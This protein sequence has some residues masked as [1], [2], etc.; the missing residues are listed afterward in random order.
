MVIAAVSSFITGRRKLL[1]V[2]QDQTAP[3]VPLACAA[4]LFRFQS[5]IALMPSIL[6]TRTRSQQ[7]GEHASRHI[8]P[9]PP[10]SGVNAAAGAFFIDRMFSDAIPQT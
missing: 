1:F 4:G 6:H 10:A 9:A 5:S 8:S 2:G 7:V 3:P